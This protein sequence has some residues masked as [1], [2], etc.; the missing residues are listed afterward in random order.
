MTFRH[1]SLVVLLMLTALIVVG[2]LYVT[3]PLTGAIARQFATDPAL[4]AWSGTAFGFA[5]AAG[6]LLWGPLSD[7]VG[8]RWVLVLGLVCTGAVTAALSQAQGI[9]SFLAGRALQGFFAASF[10]PVALS[11]LGETLP[12]ARRAFGISLI[13]FA[14]LAAAPIAQVV[15]AGISVPL[16]AFM[17]LLAPAYVALAA[18]IALA[19]PAG[20]KPA[21]VAAAGQDGAGR[22]LLGTPLIVLSWGAALTVLFGFVTFQAGTAAGLGG[23]FDPQLVRLVGLP[24]LALSLFAAAIARRLGG[25]VTVSGL[26]LILAAA[27]LLVAGLSGPV[28]LAAAA[29]VAAGVGLAVPGLIATIAGAATQTNRGLAL[30]LYT[31]ALFVGASVAPP[32]STVLQP[33]GLWPL[34]GLP[35]ALLLIAALGLVLGQR[36]QSPTLQPIQN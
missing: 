2:Q 21:A 13:S 27:G 29:L 3:I 31:F 19:L 33:L 4:A 24:P 30:A 5:Y 12:P 15:A 36:R 22:G 20:T 8:R 1:A 18:G 25:P 17:L 10:P 26:G 23:G 34:Y 6:F 16:T 32:A 28:T 7:R 35:A 14:F 11:L 9:E